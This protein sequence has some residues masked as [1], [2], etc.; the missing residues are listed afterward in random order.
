MKGNSRVLAKAFGNHEGWYRVFVVIFWTLCFLGVLWG[1]VI[2]ADGHNDPTA[3]LAIL[4]L[5]LFFCGGFVAVMLLAR[6][7]ITGFKDAKKDTEN[8]RKTVDE[9]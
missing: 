4:I 2:T 8:S 7:I 1:I 6:W 5:P 9:M 3:P